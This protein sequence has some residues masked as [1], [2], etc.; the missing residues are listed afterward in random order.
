MSF[1][2]KVFSFSYEN[3]LPVNCYP[4]I[5]YPSWNIQVFENK[6]SKA[7]TIIII[8]III[9]IIRTYYLGSIKYK[10]G[11]SPYNLKIK[12]KHLTSPKISKISK[13][14]KKK[15]KNGSADGR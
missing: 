15:K 1:L 13:K 3:Y 7:C 5:C 2:H 14:K 10:Y 4:E 12:M 6:A 9:I 8:I 11:S